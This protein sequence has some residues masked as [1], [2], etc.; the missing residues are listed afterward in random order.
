M[1]LSLFQQLTPGVPRPGQGPMMG[2]SLHKNRHFYV[3]MACYLPGGGVPE[4]VPDR[5]L[6]YVVL[7]GQLTLFSHGRRTVLE[8]ND[9]FSAAPGDCH[10]IRNCSN[11]PLRVL[12]IIGGENAGPPEA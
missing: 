3:G 9:S 6:C 10:E 5:D 8:V 4:I 11:L 1:K 2:F 7:E 12:V